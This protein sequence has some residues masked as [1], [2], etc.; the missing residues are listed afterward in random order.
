MR[1]RSA[2]TARAKSDYGRRREQAKL[3]I[4][5]SNNSVHRKKQQQQQ[6]QQSG[7]PRYQTPPPFHHRFRPAAAARTPARVLSELQRQKCCALFDMHAGQWINATFERVLAGGSFVE[8]EGDDGD[9]G[10]KDGGSTAAVFVRVEAQ[11]RSAPSE[12]VAVPVTRL[13]LAAERAREESAAQSSSSRGSSSASREDQGHPPVG[14]VISAPAGFDVLFTSSQNTSGWILVLRE[15][16]KEP[17]YYNRNHEP[18]KS[19]Y[20]LPPGEHV[21]VVI[22]PTGI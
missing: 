7:R 19:T 15:G 12:L 10:A 1:R 22:Q 5:K 16:G 20:N 4:T 14:R 8:T 21:E 18:R 13:F 3:A 9:G 2:R 17:Y 11:G 6:Q